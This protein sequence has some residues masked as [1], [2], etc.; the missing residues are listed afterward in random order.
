MVRE[1]IW[2]EHNQRNEA[3]S[4]A[5]VR[6]HDGTGTTAATESAGRAA[7]VATNP[8]DT[9]NAPCRDQADGVE[10]WVPVGDILV[11]ATPEQAALFKEQDALLYAECARLAREHA[12]AMAQRTLAHRLR[13]TFDSIGR[14]FQRNRTRST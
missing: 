6:P 12:E 7:A 11:P 5:A 1:G 14:R 3:T 4:A 8:E 13:R 2:T 10:Y 9:P